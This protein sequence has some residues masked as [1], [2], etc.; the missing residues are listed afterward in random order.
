MV[1]MHVVEIDRHINEFFVNV[2]NC[3][4]VELPS[5]IL[6]INGRPIS[7]IVDLDRE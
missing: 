3:K 5:V 1:Q 4:A 2:V 6:D 7:V